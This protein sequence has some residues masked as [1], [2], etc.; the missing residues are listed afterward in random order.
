VEVASAEEE[1]VAASLLF[2]RCGPGEKK[3]YI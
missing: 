2:S 3:G 1:E